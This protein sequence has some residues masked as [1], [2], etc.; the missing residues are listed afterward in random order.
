MKLAPFAGAFG[1]LLAAGHSQQPDP[2]TLAASLQGR[3]PTLEEAL[4]HKLIYETAEGFVAANRHRE[5]LPAHLEQL[6]SAENNDR[7][8]L[9]SEMAR[10]AGSGASWK[11]MGAQRIKL[12]WTRLIPG[13]LRE[14]PR[15][16][17]LVEAW[18]TP[19]FSLQ[20][21]LQLTFEKLDQR[22]RLLL[23]GN[24]NAPRPE[25]STSWENARSVTER[26]QQRLPWATELKRKGILAE[27]IDGLLVKTGDLASEEH[28]RLLAVDNSDRTTLFQIITLQINDPSISSAVVASNRA[29]MTAGAR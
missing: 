2:A 22:E 18:P 16:K 6:V 14:D 29:K 9:Y 11:E 7:Q 5:P 27:G 1:L 21:L 24:V 13:I 26:M 12:Y 15:T 25:D 28:Q 8:S 20:D 10:K 4:R 3:Q 17:L 19:V 23:S